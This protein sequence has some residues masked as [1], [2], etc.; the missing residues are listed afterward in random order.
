MTKAVS[1][2]PGHKHFCPEWD[3][4]EINDAMPEFEACLCFRP[5]V[6]TP[7]PQQEEPAPGP[8]ESRFMAIMNSI[9]DEEADY[10]IGRCIPLLQ[11]LL[12]EGNEQAK[13]VLDEIKAYCAE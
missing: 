5:K 3:F 10:I 13:E 8:V 12:H 4:L 2:T 11:I 6:S 1:T 7:L 9:K